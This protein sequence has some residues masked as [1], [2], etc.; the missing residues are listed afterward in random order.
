MISGLAL[1]ILVGFFFEEAQKKGH[2]NKKYKGQ[3]EDK[4]PF[5][6]RISGMLTKKK[7]HDG[8]GPTDCLRGPQTKGK[9]P[10]SL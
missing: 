2:L 7:S 3:S 9:N 10:T 4:N 5:S 8:G 6:A 1:Y